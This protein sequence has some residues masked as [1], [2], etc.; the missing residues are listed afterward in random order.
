MDQT[1]EKLIRLQQLDGEIRQLRTSL[2]ATPRRIRGIENELAAHAATIR[3]LEERQSAEETKRRRDESDLKDQ[4]AKIAKSRQQLNIVQNQA[5][6]TALEH[7]ITF[8][9][10]EISRLEDD[11]LESMERSD[12]IERDLLAARQQ[13]QSHAA[14]LVSEKASSERSTLLEQA[15][16]TK[17]QAERA[18]LR[19]EIDEDRLAEYDR[20]AAARGTAIARARDQRC[21]GCQMGLRP[22]LWNQLRDGQSLKC[23]SC[24][25]ILYVDNRREPQIETGRPGSASGAQTA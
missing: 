1:L 5:Q 18:A 12:I 13:H 23:E 16:L 19:P 11:E 21:T 20:I 25:R 15:D 17:W 2:E 3:S 4:Q 10:H 7:Q 8:A 24:G 14:Y 22:Q 9:E 6:A